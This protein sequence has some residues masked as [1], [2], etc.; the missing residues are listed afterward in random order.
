[1]LGEKGYEVHLANPAAIQKYKGVKHTD[2]RLDANWLAEML[3]SNIPPE[4][5]IYPREEWPIRV[6]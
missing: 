3:R 1:M 5:Y 4:G 6:Y 2:D